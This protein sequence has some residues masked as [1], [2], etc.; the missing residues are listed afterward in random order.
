MPEDVIQYILKYGYLAIFVLVFL[1]EVGAPNPIP[2]ELVLL[3]S[4]YLTFM[5]ILKF[6]LVIL[7]VVLADFAGTTILHTVFHYSGAYIIQHKPRW[8][9]IPVKTIFKLKERM[10]K[11]GLVAIYIGRLSPFIR[12]YTSVIAGLLQ[13]KSS[14]YLPI[15]LITAI[16][17]A[18]VYITAGILLGPFWNHV[19]PNIKNVKFIMLLVLGAV[20]LIILLRA[21]IKHR[22][23]KNEKSDDILTF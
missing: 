5:G 4:G 16:I 10:S 22:N 21:C 18:T 3:F 7:A 1:Q 23:V 12:G 8:L 19:I 17:W 9:P 11:G 14:V 6:P 15:A 2:N 13:I 20:I